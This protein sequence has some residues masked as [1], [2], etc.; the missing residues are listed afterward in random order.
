MTLPPGFTLPP[1][2]T[3]VKPAT[4]TPPVDCIYDV[5]PEE[6][7]P[8]KPIEYDE[9]VTAE[10]TPEG[11]VVF[12]FPEPR[13]LTEVTLQAPDGTK[14]EVVPVREDGTEGQPKDLKS[15]PDKPKS[16]KLKESDVTKVIVRAKDGNPVTPADIVALEVTACKEGKFSC[17]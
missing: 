11:T 9:G 14:L 7:I 6:L 16:T 3:T 8:D 10:L 13:K 15:S 17:I 12:T 1:A 5:T 4:T 2:Y